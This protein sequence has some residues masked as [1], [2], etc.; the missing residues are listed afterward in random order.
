MVDPQLR[1]YVVRENT[2][3]VNHNQDI[4]EGLEEYN[5]LDERLYV[6]NP[7]YLGFLAGLGA[8]EPTEVT[9]SASLEST[10]MVA[11]GTYFLT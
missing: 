4:E 8:L 10:Y 1:Y 11:T 3:F 5:E 7:S 9:W 2:K 6:K